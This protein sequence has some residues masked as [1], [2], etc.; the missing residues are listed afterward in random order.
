LKIFLYNFK[1]P[2]NLIVLKTQIV[3][4][5]TQKDSTGQAKK[6]HFRS[7]TIW[8]KQSDGKWKN[9]VDIMCPKK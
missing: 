9:V 1:R 3:S 8:K 5:L 7:V 2:L 4:T 6:E